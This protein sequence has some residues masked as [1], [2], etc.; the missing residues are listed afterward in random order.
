MKFV[1]FRIH[2]YKS[3][4]DSG[5]CFLSE[6]ITILAGKN[7][8]GKTSVLEALEDCQ[9]GK[10]I[11]DAAKPIG[12][13]LMPNVDLFFRLSEEETNNILAEADLDKC[14]LTDT[15]IGIRK[16][17][18]EE[19]YELIDSDGIFDKTETW[20]EIVSK[21]TNELRGIDRRLGIVKLI[22]QNPS[23]CIE[24]LSKK[25]DKQTIVDNDNKEQIE[26]PTETDTAKIKNA[27]ALATTYQDNET[28]SKRFL[29]AFLSAHLPYFIL[30]SSFNDTFPDSIPVSDYQQIRGQRIWRL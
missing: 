25:I 4:K 21:M 9:E 7:E 29:G 11:R 28:R 14:V 20:A 23:N 18:G 27:I 17:T 6:S 12:A 10:T 2:N 5:N 1:N 30:F 24:L 3:I 19:R 8:S 15:V 16:Q 22:N 26:I 13:D